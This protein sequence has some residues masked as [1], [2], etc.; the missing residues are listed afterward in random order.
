MAKKPAIH[1]V[2]DGDGGWINR[3]EG[4]SRGFGGAPRKADAE[5]A[6][7]DSAERRETE[8]VSHRRDGTIGERRSYGNDPHPP[9]G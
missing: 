8:H 7:R 4:S 5:R 6:G 1:T 3:S 9:K 2:P